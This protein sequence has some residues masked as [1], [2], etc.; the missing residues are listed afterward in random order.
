MATFTLT[1]L[2][3]R[4]PDGTS[5]GAYLAEQARQDQAPLGVAVNTQTVVAGAAAFT[6]L[7]DDRSYA[8][9]ALVSG[10]YRYV[11]FHTDAVT[12]FG[13]GP[14]GPPGPAG[15][16][17][18]VG[19][20]GAAGATGPAGAAGPS[21]S[22]GPAGPAG[23][24]GST[25]PAGATGP[26]GP[27]AVYGGRLVAYNTSRSSGKGTVA[28]GGPRDG[29]DRFPSKLAGLLGMQEIM[30]AT[31]GATVCWA[32]SNPTQG[33]GWPTIMHRVRRP[34]P[35]ATQNWGYP[36]PD[37]VAT[38]A[39]WVNDAA[40]INNGW[41]EGPGQPATSTRINARSTNIG[42][43]AMRFVISHA[44]ASAIWE[45][46]TTVGV[47]WG[48][49]TSQ[50]NVSYNATRVRPFQG[51]L[52]GPQGYRSMSDASTLTL[53]LPA[54]YPGSATAPLAICFAG[55]DGTTA[56]TV[57]SSGTGVP[58]KTLDLT[59]TVNADPY[60]PNPLMIRFTGSDLA[61]GSRNVVLTISSLAGSAARFLRAWIE[62]PTPPVVLAYNTAQM[63]PSEGGIFFTH[64]RASDYTYWNTMLSQVVAEFGSHAR[65]LDINAVVGGSTPTDTTRSY[66]FTDT[67]H[68]ESFGNAEYALLGYSSVTGATIDA[69]L[70]ARA[71]R[72]RATQQDVVYRGTLSAAVSIASSAETALTPNVEVDDHSG[73]HDDTN[74][75]TRVY[76]TH[77]GW[78]TARLAVSWGDSATGIRSVGVKVTRVD[79]T[80]ETAPYTSTSA[81]GS[82]AFAPVESRTVERV[83]MRPGDYVEFIV[84][85]SSGAAL[86]VVVSPRAPVI[87]LR[88]D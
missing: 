34:A 35:D 44:C 14:P 63:N 24:A 43:H 7:V 55:M 49:T 75:L 59:N 42:K 62:S 80:V 76:C 48:G 78:H 65:Y 9:Y 47:A 69:D 1:A 27:G 6:G 15:P 20:A 29:A 82:S 19:A 40:R 22:A 41:A 66:F 46:T 70:R 17:G 73:M 81:S 77:E 2:G 50:V 30:Y 33:G 3:D 21:G 26:S 56:G 61:S 87:E 64:M 32:E 13:T 79:A 52:A 4:Y 72:S 5:L 16:A 37:Q 51:A 8:A 85:Q 53:T 84:F 23:A 25:G 39:D 36:Q 12:G 18:A 31:A 68:M 67:M 58:T 10:V 54:D 11:Y 74:N 86:N 88:R 60:S 28:A 38:I 45:P 83:Y 57:T 71:R